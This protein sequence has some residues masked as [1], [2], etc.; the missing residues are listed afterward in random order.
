LTYPKRRTAAVK[1][2]VAGVMNQPQIREGVCAPV[3]LG[4]PMMHVKFLAIFQVLMAHRTDALL[5]VDELS[6][7]K[8]RHL[9]FRSSLS[10]VVL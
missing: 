4:N 9:E 6:A 2:A 1:L 3:F 7:T 5:L 10:P 8:H